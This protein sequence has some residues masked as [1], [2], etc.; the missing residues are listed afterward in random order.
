MYNI[1]HTGKKSNYEYSER[2]YL[3]Y[4]EKN[5]FHTFLTKKER[6][7]KIKIKLYEEDW[8]LLKISNK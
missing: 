7:K 8:L 5:N 3:K 6:I 2:K 1:P 4:G